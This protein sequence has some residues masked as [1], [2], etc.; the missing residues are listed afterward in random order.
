[1]AAAAK[2]PHD[3]PGGLILP[4]GEQTSSVWMEKKNHT[5][6]LGFDG[7]KCGIYSLCNHFNMQER[8]KMF[9]K[10]SIWGGF[11]QI[12]ASTDKAARHRRKESLV[13]RC[14]FGFTLTFRHSCFLRLLHRCRQL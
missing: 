8:L 2:E 3:L 11:G 13:P 9:R 7:Y 14:I 6:S 5:W 12:I 10:D 4:L 1:M